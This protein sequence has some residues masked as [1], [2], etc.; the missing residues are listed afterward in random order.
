VSIR[1]FLTLSVYYPDGD[2]W[3]EDILDIQ[4]VMCHKYARREEDGNE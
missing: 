3:T 2:I 4:A 1:G